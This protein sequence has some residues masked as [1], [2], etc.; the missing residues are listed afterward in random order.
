MEALWAGSDAVG[1]SGVIDE[2]SS[3]RILTMEYVAG[4]T[5][6]EA[7]AD[8]RPQALR[9]RGG[10]VAPDAGGAPMRCNVYATR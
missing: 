6:D 8:A 7:C 4:Y 5:P 9:D 2:A 3:R 10:S 1:N